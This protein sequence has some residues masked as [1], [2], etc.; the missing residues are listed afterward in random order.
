MWEYYITKT[1]NVTQ[2]AI[3]LAETLGV[4]SNEDDISRANRLPSKQRIT[5]THQQKPESNTHPLIIARFVD[6]YKRNQLYEI[7][8]KAKDISNFPV[9]NMAYLHINKNLDTKK[10]TIV[11]ENKVKHKRN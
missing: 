3:D 2:V 9:K 6:Q 11:L 1:E 7:R 5:H 8:Y 10:Q 4:K